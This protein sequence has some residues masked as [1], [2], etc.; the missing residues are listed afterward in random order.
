MNVPG[1]VWEQAQRAPNAVAVRSGAEDLTYA[2]LVG[3]AGR[4]AGH[5]GQRG[6]R[7]DE[8]IG[9]LLGRSPES[10]VAGLGVLSAGA[11]YLPLDPAHPSSR[12]ISTL[13]DAGAR[14]LLTDADHLASVRGWS[15]EALM[16]VELSRSEAMLEAPTAESEQIAYVI[17]TSGST[18]RPKGVEVRHRN[19]MNLVEWHQSAFAIGKKDV[20]TLVSGPAFDAA[21][22]EVWPY[23]SAGASVTIAD[24]ETRQAPE[25]LRD[26]LVAERATVSFV[27]TV[28][29]EQLIRLSWPAD[30][31]LRILLTGAET[32][33][34]YPPATLPFRLVNNYGPTECTVVTTSGLVPA[35]GDAERLPSIG[36]PIS[37]ASVHLFGPGGRP[38]AQGEVGEMFIGGASV[39]DGYRNDPEETAAR[40]VADPFSA[41]AAARLYRS[42]DLAR[43]NE[44]GELEFLGRVDEQV[45][46]RGYRVEPAEVALTLNRHPAI[47]TSFVVLRGEG[48]DA[49]L[50]AYIVSGF[51]QALSDRELTAFLR[52]FLPEYMV[53]ARF[54][55]LEALPLTPNG[56][57]DRALLPMAETI[58][59]YGPYVAPSTPLERW[60]ADLVV[61]LLELDKV[62]VED[63]F[64]MLGGHSLLGTQLIARIR[65]AFGVDIP[66]RTLFER[67]T[68]AELAGAVKEIQAAQL[69]GVSPMQPVPADG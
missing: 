49:Q 14:Y 19:L 64:F 4:V 61:D 43:L 27:P 41:N 3:Q 52:R 54:V 26:W 37:G 34:S 62:S 32:L 1:L 36:R 47:H 13:A 6:L 40:F 67:P 46:I 11:A 53:P 12:L 22:W 33:R 63:D 18:G 24:D 28:L 8:V 60:I 58:A 23:L 65:A 56:K 2:E 66:L 15:G 20:G 59:M 35:R 39:A 42:G 10:I 9:I 29:A 55:F 16:V 30:T 48:A 68:V 21:V 45:K 51:G 69:Q 25:R 50:V 38:V 7:R 31:S 5:L 17:Y 57:V 44:E